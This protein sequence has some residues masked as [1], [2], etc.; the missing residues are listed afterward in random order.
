MNL[1]DFRYILHRVNKTEDS[2]TGRALKLV[3][4]HGK[5]PIEAVRST[6][7]PMVRFGPVIDAAM[8]IRKAMVLTEADG[9][10]ELELP[11][12]NRALVASRRKES[13]YEPSTQDYYALEHLKKRG[14]R[15][16]KAANLSV[17]DLP[18]VLLSTLWE[19]EA[20]GIVTAESVGGP[21]FEWSLTAAG[22]QLLKERSQ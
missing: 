13:A 18:A 7:V 6:G 19:L 14:G 3:L 22:D 16:R 12:A 11:V 21:V 4:V 20:R 10:T 15:A 17:D 2:P 8:K 1:E 5:L 9:F